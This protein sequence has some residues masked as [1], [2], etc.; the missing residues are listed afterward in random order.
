MIR[1]RFS[2]L[3][4]L[5][6]KAVFRITQQTNIE[7]IVSYMKRVFIAPDWA[8]WKDKQNSALAHATHAV[9]GWSLRFSVLK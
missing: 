6:H 4:T 9:A 1:F 7:S 3:K 8:I 2:R 5:Q